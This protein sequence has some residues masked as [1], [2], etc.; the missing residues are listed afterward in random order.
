MDR[1]KAF[2]VL[3]KKRKYI[4]DDVYVQLTNSIKKD[5]KLENEKFEK[6]VNQLLENGFD[7]V[8]IKNTIL[9]EFNK[10]ELLR[11]F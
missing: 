5:L 4:E 2:K 6:S 8:V 1:K 10:P 11:S 7:M 9:S 3:N